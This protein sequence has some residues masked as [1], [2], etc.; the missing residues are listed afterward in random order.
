LIIFLLGYIEVF[1]SN[2]EE[3]TQMT[4]SNTHPDNENN[5]PNANND[6]WHEPVVRLRG[7]PYNSSKEDVVRFFDGT[8][9][10]I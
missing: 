4:K 5:S 2:S 6:N 3:M 1:E 8:Y 7:L 10:L 9:I